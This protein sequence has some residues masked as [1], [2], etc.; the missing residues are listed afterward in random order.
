M[1]YAYFMVNDF[2]AKVEAMRANPKP[3]IANLGRKQTQELGSTLFPL[4]GDLGPVK[5]LLKDLNLQAAQESCATLS[6]GMVSDPQGLPRFV[7]PSKNHL[8]LLG[9]LNNLISASIFKAGTHLNWT[10]V[11][12]C[13]HHVAGW[14]SKSLNIGPMWVGM[15]GSFTE[16]CLQL[17]GSTQVDMN[18]KWMVVPQGTAHR[19]LPL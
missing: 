4:V 10:T 7:C 8:R 1:L 6:L 13:Q 2:V 19:C 3:T 18:G 5:T 16:G 15:L 17:Q 12:M 11:D 9:M 14:K